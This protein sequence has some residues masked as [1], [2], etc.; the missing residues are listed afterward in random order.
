MK[1]NLNRMLTRHVR[2]TTA[3]NHSSSNSFKFNDFS[4]YANST[5]VHELFRETIIT[6]GLE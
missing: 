6:V 5:N 4:V 3:L 1:F 2:Q